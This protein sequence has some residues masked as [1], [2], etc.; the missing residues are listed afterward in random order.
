MINSAD[1]LDS[2]VNNFDLLPQQL[3][4]VVET[5][6]HGWVLIPQ[7]LPSNLIQGGRC[8]FILVCILR[9]DN[10]LYGVSTPYVDRE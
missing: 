2:S 10:A 1:Y 6:S 8:L 3:G 4:H 5:L 9:C 7:Y